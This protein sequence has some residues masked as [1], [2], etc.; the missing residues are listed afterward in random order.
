MLHRPRRRPWRRDPHSCC[1]SRCSGATSA[2]PFRLRCEQIASRIGAIHDRQLAFGVHRLLRRP[3][4]GGDGGPLPLPDRRGDPAASLR[5]HRA[6]AR[7]ARFEPYR[8]RRSRCGRGQRDRRLVRAQRASAHRCD[9]RL[10]A[11]APRAAL[12]QRRAP[13]AQ[14]P[15]RVRSDAA[16]RQRPRLQHRLPPRPAEVAADAG[17]PLPLPPQLRGRELEH[18]PQ[19]LHRSRRAPA[20]HVRHGRGFVGLAAA[21]RWPARAGGRRHQRRDLRAVEGH[22]AQRRGRAPLQVGRRRQYA[23]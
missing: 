16:R 19:R 18:H 13:A 7:N 8:G 6:A 15:A 22:H 2:F 4:R 21:H 10:G 1:R 14:P 11:A 3:G 12:V 17:A 5:P 23:G 9:A 20:A